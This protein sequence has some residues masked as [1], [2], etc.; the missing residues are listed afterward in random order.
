MERIRIRRADLWTAD[1][2]LGLPVQASIPT[3]PRNTG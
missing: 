2:L 1:L 3:V